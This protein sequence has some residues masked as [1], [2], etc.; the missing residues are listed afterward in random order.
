MNQQADEHDQH[1]G[2]Q[3][4]Q[5]IPPQEGRHDE[6]QPEHTI[7]SE[8]HRHPDDLGD[9]IADGVE[10]PDEGPRLLLRDQR[11]GG[12]EHQGKEEDAEH[13]EVRGRL[14]RI[15]RHDVHEQVG[16]EA[17]GPARLQ[18]GDLPPVG[19]EQLL[20]HL[21]GHAH[22]GTH[23]IHERDADHGGDHG[24]QEEVGER[25][26]PHAAHFPDVTELCHAE[27]D[28]RE[29]ERHHRHEEQPQEDL[30][31]GTGDVRVDPA[32]PQRPARPEVDR[33]TAQPAGQQTHEDL[34]VQLHRGS[35]PR[36]RTRL[37]RTL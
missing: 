29:H 23:E 30:T 21:D 8:V 35:S 28:G 14:D 9:R 6:D 20:A 36:R 33:E 12:T 37:C 34:G 15:A 4:T 11:E 24:G 13:I 31:H 17:R 1:V 26:H 22:A 32:H 3:F 25:P 19:I 27:R 7:G 18:A 10:H 16:A 5:D 2:E